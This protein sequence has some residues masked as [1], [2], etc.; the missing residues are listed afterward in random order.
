VG[1]RSSIAQSSDLDSHL[2]VTDWKSAHG[3]WTNIKSMV[4]R[5]PDAY[6][7]VYLTAEHQGLT[8]G[9]YEAIVFDGETEDL[10]G[11]HSAVTGL[12]TVPAAGLYSIHASARVKD[13][14]VTAHT[15]GIGIMVNGALVCAGDRTEGY[16]ANGLSAGLTVSATLRLA[17]GDTVGI[18]I[19]C[20]NTNAAQRI[21]GGA[22]VTWMTVC[23]IR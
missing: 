5:R 14:A 3:I 10:A 23:M 16:L 22:T 17:A 21:T 20:N 4:C 8:S 18:G 19:Y 2:G 11:L 15:F 9:S 13:V 6:V 7:S 1:K 12:T